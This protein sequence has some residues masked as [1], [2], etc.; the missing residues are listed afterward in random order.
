MD[1][2]NTKKTYNK[3]ENEDFNKYANLMK[4]NN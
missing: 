3:R 1:N 4:Y 2:K